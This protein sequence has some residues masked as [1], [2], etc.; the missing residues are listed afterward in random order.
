MS[1]TFT[2]VAQE[3]HSQYVIGFT[4]ESLDG[5]LHALQVRVKRPK[6]TARARKSYIASPD[7]LRQRARSGPDNPGL[8]RRQATSIRL[9]PARDAVW[10]RNGPTGSPPGRD[11]TG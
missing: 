9:R 10:K 1:S 4:P 7:K 5:K 3:L 11:Q 6:M 2:R 8:P